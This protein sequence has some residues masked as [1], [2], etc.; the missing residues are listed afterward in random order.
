M[1]KV[2]IY[3]RLSRED[4]DKS[5]GDDSQSIANQKSML[6]AYCKERNW[7][8]YDIYCDDGFSGTDKNRPDFNR[9]LKDCEQHK[10]DTVICKDLSR[11]SR[12]NT[13]IDQIVY[14]RFIEWGIRFIGV[15]DNSNNNTDN[16]TGV[17]LFMGA[18]NE[19]YVQDISRKI[20]KTM[21]YKRKQGEYVGSFAPY[22][23]MKNPDNTKQLI[24]DDESAETVIS[25]F[26]MFANGMSYRKIIQHLND[27][28]ILSPSA[29]KA[30]KGSNYVC[31]SLE[32][33]NQK[34]LWTQ[35]TIYKIL[36][37]ETYIGTLVQGKTHPI[38]HKNKK[39]KKVSKE[40]WI[41]CPNAHEP[42]ISLEL[43]NKAQ[44]RIKNRVRSD[45]VTLELSPLA[46]KVKC[47]VCGRPMKRHVYWNKNHTIKY[48]NLQ[49]ATNKIGAMNCSNGHAISGLQL[50]KSI[51]TQLNG[52]IKAYCN[53]DDIVIEDMAEHKLETLRKRIDK[54]NEQKTVLTTRLENV[55]ADKLDGLITKDEYLKYK[56][57]FEFQLSELETQSVETAENIKQ[58]EESETD[59][60][61][62]M[63]LIK[64]YTQV[65]E[66][67]RNIAD[68]FIDT[69]YI[70]ERNEKGERDI[71]ID[72]K[73]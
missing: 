3:V 37:D 11:F 33:S 17:R 25:I 41:R 22:G 23:Y 72:W 15:S 71:S 50:E 21:E 73:I 34:D 19:Y 10:V 4:I 48:Y 67:T 61:Y 47:A 8:I 57:K 31:T 26:E 27:N 64:K 1:N 52:I 58:C 60:E 43:W 32:G 5:K 35:S 14:E 2:A 42:I 59:I 38:S 62:N 39:R 65:K 40:D 46:G 66:L 68:E 9:M 24:I 29:Y 44:E 6:S 56:E 20:R 53:S 18:F 30:N 70:C 12:D 28:E 45:R 63:N 55:Y 13:V 49:C 16:D 7:D 51:L 69:V 36:R 54:I